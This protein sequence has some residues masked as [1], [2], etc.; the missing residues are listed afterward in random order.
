MSAETKGV[1]KKLL[2]PLVLLVRWWL[3]KVINDTPSYLFLFKRAD[4]VVI[5]GSV[6]GNLANVE[7]GFG[8]LEPYLRL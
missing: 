6:R 3:T 8:L 4:Y 1:V 2:D 7:L 5:L